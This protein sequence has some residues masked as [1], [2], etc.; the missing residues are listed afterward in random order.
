MIEWNTENDQ[1]LIK[2]YDEWAKTYDQDTANERRYVAP[3]VG[4]M[5]LHEFLKNNKF[6]TD[7]RILDVG[8]GTGLVA[9][10][11]SKLNYTNID[12]LDP[13]KVSNDIARSKNIYQN[14]I[15]ECFEPG[16]EICIP[17]NTYNAA[18]AIGVFTKG[19]IKGENNSMEEMVRVVK[20]GES[21]LAQVLLECVLFWV[22]CAFLGS[23][24]FSGIPVLFWDPCAFLG[25][26]CFS[27]I[28]VLF[29]DPCAFLESLYEAK[30]REAAL[31]FR[32]PFHTNQDK[33][34]T[35][36][37][38]KLLRN[39][40]GFDPG[41]IWAGCKIGNKVVVVVDVNVGKPIQCRNG[42]KPIQCKKGGKPIQFRNGEKPIQCRNEGKPIQYRNGGKPIQCRNGG[43]PIQ[44]RNGGKPIQCR[45]GGKPIQCRNGGKPQ[46]SAESEES[47]K[48]IQKRRKANSVQKRRKA[49]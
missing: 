4:A 13:S 5:T 43:N 3:E 9:E 8:S 39:L 17:S 48:S 22:P 19:H 10:H 49:N 12:A 18:I 41:L 21:C 35:Y 46:I 1:E 2:Y 6:G 36:E 29:W 16:K 25:S 31:F 30:D 24:C 27:G 34:Q 23:L 45:N 44:S 20:P 7:C 32:N 47:Y 11:L 42:G 26:L 37:L 40:A 28:P 15:E 33:N 14:I 38:A